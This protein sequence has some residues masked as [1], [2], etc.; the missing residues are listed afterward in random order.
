[1]IVRTKKYQLKTGTYV[2]V[3]LVT[4]LKRQWWLTIAPIAIASAT[5]FF[6]NTI[7]FYIS[8]LL[9]VILYVLFWL[10][11]FFGVTQVEQNKILFER[12][13]YEIDPRYV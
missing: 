10:I 1:M 5:F 8:A 7:W 12:I 3:A 11:Q 4:L 2:R 9:V 13:G 6:P